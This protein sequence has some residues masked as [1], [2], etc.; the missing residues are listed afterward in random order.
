MRRGVG[1]TRLGCVADD[2]RGE[3]GLDGMERWGGWVSKAGGDYGG[4]LVVV[5]VVRMPGGGDGG[6]GGLGRDARWGVG[7]GWGGWGAG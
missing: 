5:G 7:V 2:C 6:S 4:C 1:W 3:A